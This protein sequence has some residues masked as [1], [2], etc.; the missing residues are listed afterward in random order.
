MPLIGQRL[1]LLRSKRLQPG[2]NKLVARKPILQASRDLNA[3]ETD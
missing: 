3:R 1:N 2:C